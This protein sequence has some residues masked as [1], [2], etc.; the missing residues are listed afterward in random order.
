MK[1]YI[2]ILAIFCTVCL[3]AAGCVTPETPPEAGATVEIIYTNTGQMPMLLAT[4]QIDGYM[5]WQPFV[6]VAT[7]SGIGKVVSYSQDL[8]PDKIWED[9]TCCALVTQDVMIEENPALVNAMSAL[10]IAADDYI[11]ANPDRTAEIT[12]Q[13]LFGGG[14]MTFGDVSVNSV[15][16]LKASLPTM[17]FT[18]EPSEKWVESNHQFI[19]AEKDLGYITG[20]LLNATPEEA[21]ALLFDFTPYEKARAMVDAKSIVTPEKLSEPIAL[22]YLPSDHDAPVFVLIKEWEYFQDTYGIALKPRS[23]VPGKVDVADLI[24]NGETIGEVKLVRG[25]GG[26]QLM[27]LMASDAIQFAD[28]GTPP[29]I[30]AIDKGTPIKILHP[31]QTEGSGFVVAADA[32]AQDWSSFIEWV[33]QRT[34]EGKPLK[35]ASPL[36]GSI[37]D[38]Q[39]KNALQDSGV[40]VTEA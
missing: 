30:S 5:V 28:V 26:P 10:I 38:V 9:H 21:D 16:V 39:I 14:E 27:T 19:E 4:D 18:T 8:P 40:V 6:A 32:P 2:A 31:I 1:P 7:E 24:V 34:A 13:W 25:E 22:G 12:A 20:Q 33:K 36:K 37:Q 11:T 35:I 29:S 3:L 15:D 23:D 17:K